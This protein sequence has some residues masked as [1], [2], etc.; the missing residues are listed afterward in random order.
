MT[1]YKSSNKLDD[2]Y[3]DSTEISKIYKGST[4]V[5]EKKRCTCLGF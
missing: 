5:Y 4:L 2:I 1:I 3:V